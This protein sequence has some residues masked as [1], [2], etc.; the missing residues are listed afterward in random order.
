MKP[1]NKRRF[2]VRTHLPAQ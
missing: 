1:M 2:T